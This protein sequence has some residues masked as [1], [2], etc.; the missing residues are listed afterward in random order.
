MAIWADA[1]QGNHYTLAG[2]NTALAAY[3]HDC[4]S[5]KEIGTAVAGKQHRS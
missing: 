4:A 3:A 1:V 5:N 2:H